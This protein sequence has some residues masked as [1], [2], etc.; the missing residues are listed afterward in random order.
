MGSFSARFRIELVVSN[1]A[2]QYNGHG[3]TQVYAGDSGWTNY[4]LNVAVK[5]ATLNNYPGRIEPFLIDP[6]TVPVRSMVYP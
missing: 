2:L 1:G 5:L 4:N 3:H 6:T